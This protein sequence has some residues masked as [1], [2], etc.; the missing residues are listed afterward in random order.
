MI[1][2]LLRTCKSHYEILAPQGGG[3]GPSRSRDTRP[4]CKVAIKVL[5]AAL[6]QIFQDLHRMNRHASMVRKQLIECLT[7]LDAELSDSSQQT[8]KLPKGRGSERTSKK[9]GPGDGD[10]A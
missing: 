8:G 4:D 5:P 3:A 1:G 6:L 2:P 10:G 7:R 9:R